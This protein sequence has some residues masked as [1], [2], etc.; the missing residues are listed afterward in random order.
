ME[1][2]G[3]FQ[4]GTL[5]GR[6]KKALK[7]SILWNL[8]RDEAIRTQCDKDESGSAQRPLSKTSVRKFN[9]AT[10]QFEPEK[11]LQLWK[12]PITFLFD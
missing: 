2:W 7:N 8:H 6:W 10:Q 3:Q 12:I 9:S 1:D 11:N 4:S 5:R